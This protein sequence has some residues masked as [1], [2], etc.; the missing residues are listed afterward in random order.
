MILRCN[1]FLDLPSLPLYGGPNERSKEKKRMDPRET[2]KQ[3]TGF[4]KTAF[5]QSVSTIT[6]L[7]DSTEKT[8][9]VSLARSPWFPEEG[10]KLV[11]EWLRVYRKGYDDLKIAADEQ[12]RKI[13]VLFHKDNGTGSA[14]TPKKA[15]KDQ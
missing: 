12:Y 15:G 5:D 4:F 13:E 10:R 7:R 14:E 2:A 8:I 1:N 3:I 6:M 9:T 11:S